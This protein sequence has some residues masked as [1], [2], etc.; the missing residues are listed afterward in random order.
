MFESLL[1]GLILF[2]AAFVH[3]LAGFAFALFA[4][5][6][7]SLLWPLK[8]VVPLMA[9]LGF[10]V[11]AV[12]LLS[13]KRYFHIYRVLSLSLGAVPGVITGVI[14]LSQA[15]EIQLKVI[16]GL[17]L[18]SYGIW[19]LINLRP[20]ILVSDRWG[21]FFG[22]LAGALGAALNTPGPPVVVYVTLKGWPKDEVKSTLQGYF[23][24]LLIGIITAHL[25]KG[26]IIKQTFDRFL[27]FLPEVLLGLFLGHRL[28]YHLTIGL[29]LRI[30]YLLLIL[31]GLLS[32]IP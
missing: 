9:L 8:E 3:G 1:A 13:L 6:L 12:L 2:S 17:T 14:F 18:I 27:T 25:A 26:F 30:L 4:V 32:L 22:F 21:Y 11:N 23:L 16:L 20:K 29:Y 5:P 31:A 7:L 24:I 10:V 28:Y 15:P 19:G